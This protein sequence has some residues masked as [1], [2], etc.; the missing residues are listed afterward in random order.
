[1]RRTTG[2]SPAA[3]KRRGAWIR[4]RGRRAM[5][6]GRV[7]E[8]FADNLGYGFREVIGSAQVFSEKADFAFDVSFK[9]SL[10]IASHELRM[11]LYGGGP[12]DSG[13]LA[14]TRATFLKSEQG[15]AQQH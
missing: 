15:E 10:A 6:S 14:R 1:M 11:H 5:S 3:M 7:L 4:T 2:R 12:G 13:H 9:Q 8:V